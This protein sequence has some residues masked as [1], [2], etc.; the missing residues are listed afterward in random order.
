ME[1]VLTILGTIASL[2]A[3]PLSIYLYL[4]TKEAKLDKI[5]KEIV[6]TLSYQIGEERQ[7]T[8]F[9]IQTV[10]NSKIRENRFKK[11]TINI[12]EI[13]EDLVSEIISSPMIDRNKKQII[14]ADLKSIYIKDETL[15]NVKDEILDNIKEDNLTPDYL[16]HKIRDFDSKQELEERLS[17]ETKGKSYER[18]STW[19]AI[20]AA[21]ITIIFTIISFISKDSFEILFEKI[22]QNKGISSIVLGLAAGLII[23]TLT[24]LLM[25]LKKRIQRSDEIKSAEKTKYGIEIF[26][27]NRIDSETFDDIVKSNPKS[28]KYSG[29]NTEKLIS[30]MMESERFK[31]YI[32]NNIDVKVKFLFP[33]PNNKYVI[34]NFVKNVTIENKID[35]Y[36]MGINNAVKRLYDFINK[37][38]LQNRVEYKFY[39]FVPPFGLQIITEGKNDR[40]FVDLFTIGIRYRFK[41]EK[42]NSPQTY[43]IFENQFDKL[44]NISQNAS[45]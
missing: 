10:I 30:N 25:T 11:N 20:I 36:K 9:E 17:A 8:S 24:G 40:L 2:G 5:R 32:I 4:K 15:D 18:I 29:G 42:E 37:N 27:G 31:N 3:I 21:V 14:L 16:E 33:D 7:I 13:V 22:S 45:R 23:S 26:W 19:F 34:E 28:I 43:M 41:I 44:W 6:K 35:I 1:Q 39:Q 12:D 38:N